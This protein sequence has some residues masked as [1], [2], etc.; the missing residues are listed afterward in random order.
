[1]ASTKMPPLL[2]ILILLVN[3]IMASSTKKTVVFFQQPTFPSSTI[4]AAPSLLPVDSPLASPAPAAA[5]SPDHN[6]D[7]ITPLFPSP[8]GSELSPTESSLPTIPS[9]PSP[10]NPDAMSAPGPVMAF[11]PLGSLPFSS[12]LLL[13]A[14]GLT[15]SITVMGLFAFWFV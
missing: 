1:M 11:S 15:S 8:G 10:P 4:S 3:T 9:S 12:S 13:R 6:N 14:S 2:L 5:L 7:D